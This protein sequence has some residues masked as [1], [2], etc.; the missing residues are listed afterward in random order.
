MG[1][2]A[3]ARLHGEALIGHEDEL[4]ITRCCDVD[5]ESARRFAE[6]FDCD[7]HHGDWA[8]MV[9]AGDLDGV[10]LAT[11]PALHAE[12]VKQLVAA[13]I[14]HILCEKPLV[15]DAPDALA[16]WECARA[17]GAVV[18]E[19]FMYRH[20]P[21]M[22]L[23]ARVAGAEENGP[24]DYVRAQHC[25]AKTD[26]G[27][28]HLHRSGP[29]ESEAPWRTRPAA[30]GGAF[31]DIGSYAVNACTHLIGAVPLEVTA[32]GR[33]DDVFGVPEQFCGVIRYANGAMGIVDVSETA[34]SAQDVEVN[35]E[36][37]TIRLAM[38]W[39]TY[40]EAEVERRV[41]IPHE[42][43]DY[44][45]EKRVLVDRHVAPEANP[46]LCQ[47]RNLAGVITGTQQPGI[48]LA[49]SVVNSFLIS[50]LRQSLEERRF[51]TVDVPDE[52][53]AELLGQW[54]ER[55]SAVPAST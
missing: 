1:T 37:A 27:Y 38:A 28:R 5:A 19:G 17:A 20:H 50:A 47:L 2:G 3:V 42:H 12:H 10:I 16:I 23:L 43:R 15:V 6:R 24:V 22:Q 13:G 18:M 54:R 39:T 51:V 33:V 9:A 41:V 52:V 45:R 8:D 36:R 30:G 32:M 53:V 46:F 4:R 48:P 34:N 35:A 55:G 26:P 11:P 25:Y 21:A 44:G 49:E 7:S 29:P 31:Y 14:T 40:G